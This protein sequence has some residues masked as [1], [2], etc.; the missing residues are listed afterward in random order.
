MYIYIY[1]IHPILGVCIFIHSQPVFQ[2]AFLGLL[3]FQHINV[4]NL[5]LHLSLSYIH[6]LEPRGPRSYSPCLEQHVLRVPY[7]SNPT[8][9]LLSTQALSLL[10]LSRP[11]PCPREAGLAGEA[12]DTSRQWWWGERR[13][14]QGGGLR[15]ASW[16]NENSFPGQRNWRVQSGLSKTG[17]GQR[18]SL[19]EPITELG[20]IIKPGH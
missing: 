20:L 5:F 18:C 17:A 11:L 8:G 12:V 16:Y 3:I 7:T 2:F 4:I 19:T 15:E 6:A 13:S 9:F 14:G 1:I 10:V